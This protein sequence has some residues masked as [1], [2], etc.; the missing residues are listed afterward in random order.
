VP[1][2]V[3]VSR[4][5]GRYRVRVADCTRE[6]A[7]SVYDQLLVEATFASDID[8]IEEDAPPRPSWWRRLLRKAPRG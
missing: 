2:F 1:N 6:H 7:Q 5:D 4:S 8:L 3:I